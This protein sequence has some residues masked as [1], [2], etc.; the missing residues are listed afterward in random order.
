VSRQV[1]QAPQLVSYYK[2]QGL[3]P[4]VVVIGLGSNGRATPGIF[5]AIMN[6]A[7]SDHLM[8]FLTARV[9]RPWESETN[10]TI[11]DGTRRWKNSR[12]I[13]W[14]SYAGCHDDWFVNDGFHLATPGQR[15][16]A[17]FILSRL[18]GGPNLPCK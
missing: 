6:A 4:R 12:M 16:Y 18:K 2:S 1:G 8:Y 15:A 7:G 10:Q 11:L 3:L 9:P 13:D 17:A 14:R 5:D